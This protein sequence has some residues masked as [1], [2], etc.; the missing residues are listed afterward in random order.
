MTQNHE[1]AI[2]AL[3]PTT[4]AFRDLIGASRDLVGRMAKVMAMNA[5]DMTAISLLTD[6]GPMGAAELAD[7]LGIRS[8][9]ATVLIDR[10]ERAGHVERV[11]DAADRRRVTLTATGSA[12]AAALEA[13]LPSILA[14]DEVCRALTGTEKVFARDL[15]GR[16]TAAM[17]R[18]GRASQ[19]GRTSRPG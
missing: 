16:V 2:A 1:A 11:R 12:R 13:W 14:I 7:R 10:L 8:A 9:S 5:N 3:D 4:L 15:L 18:H 6:D 19:P 17:E